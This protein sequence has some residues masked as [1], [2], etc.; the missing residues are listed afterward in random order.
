MV[1]RHAE[2]FLAVAAGRC[3]RQIAAV[4]P[5]ISPQKTRVR[6][7]RRSA[8]GRLSRRGRRSREIATGCGACG[9]K[10]ASGRRKW[11]SRDPIRNAELLPEGPNL[12]AYVADDPVN[13]TDPSGQ[14]A[15]PVCVVVVVTAPAEAPVGAILVGTAIVAGVVYFIYKL[16]KKKPKPPDETCWCVCPS[17]ATFTYK[18]VAGAPCTAQEHLI[19]DWDAG[20]C[21]PVW[22]PKTETCACSKM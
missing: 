8:S 18:V 19:P 12:Y 1:Q 14:F 6:V 17:G 2:R 9:Y 5:P 10:T 3:Q 22:A 4:V 21:G 16:C 7:S 13:L 11:L 15:G 20:P